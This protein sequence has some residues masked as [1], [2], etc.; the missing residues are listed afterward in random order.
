MKPSYGPAT[1]F[2]FLA[3]LSGCARN[4]PT[5]K[6]AGSDLSGTSA[7]PAQI[8][9]LWE[10]A[11]R[12]FTGG[13]WRDAAT[14]FERLLLEFSAGDRRGPRVHFYLAECY[15]AMKDHLR[16]V[17]EFRRVSDDTPDDPLAASALLRAGDAY[18]DLWRRPELDPT[19]GQNALS[20]YEELVNRYPGGDAATR[21]RAKIAR[22]QDRFARK[23]YKAALF[24]FRARAYDSAILYLKDIVAT[25]PRAAVAPEALIKLVQAYRKLGYQEEQRETCDYIRRYHPNATGVDEVCPQTNTVSRTED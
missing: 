11:R 10:K 8:D 14:G 12:D 6:T 19:Y 22:L 2:L 3:L 21:A 18:A 24:Y 5:T 17:R 16:A 20:T 1:A 4:Q 9:S 15:F 13:K 25:Y 7:A 23:S